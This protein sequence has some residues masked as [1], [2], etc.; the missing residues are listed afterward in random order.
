MVNDP[1]IVL[2]DEPT[3]NLDGASAKAVEDLLFDLAA[4]RGTT[5]LVVTHDPGLAERAA[6]RFT[7]REGELLES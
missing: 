4:L 1:G 6:R 7:L 2:A 3:G 5:L